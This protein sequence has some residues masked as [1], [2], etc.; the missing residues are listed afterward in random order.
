MYSFNNTN[1]K[2]MSND[3]V[4]KALEKLGSYNASVSIKKQIENNNV[5]FVCS[6]SD[7][8]V[9]RSAIGEKPEFA[10]KNA[11]NEYLDAVRKDKKHSATKNI[12]AARKASEAEKNKGAEFG[13]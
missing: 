8:K 2:I 9:V 7:G 5:S 13:E 4:L 1:E 11:V 10:T 6:I 12:G 3:K